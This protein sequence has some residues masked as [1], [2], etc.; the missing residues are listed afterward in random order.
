MWEWRR[1]SIQ[2]SIAWP[3]CSGKFCSVRR[4]FYGPRRC[5]RNASPMHIQ[6]LLLP[7]LCTSLGKVLLY[8]PQ[9]CKTLAFAFQFLQFWLGALSNW[10]GLQCSDGCLDKIRLG[11]FCKSV[12]IGFRINSRKAVIREVLIFP[13]DCSKRTGMSLISTFSKFSGLN[14]VFWKTGRR[15]RVYCNKKTLPMHRWLA[16]RVALA[17]YSSYVQKQFIIY[18]TQIV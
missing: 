15:R 7:C 9:Q 6:E 4:W 16:I 3:H 8:L 12:V 17:F 14:L 11:S 18:C 13:A 5:S 1:Y 10:A 2:Y